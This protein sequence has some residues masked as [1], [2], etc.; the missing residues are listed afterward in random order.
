MT[1][2]KKRKLGAVTPLFEYSE[3]K[4]HGVPSYYGELLLPGRWLGLLLSA[5]GEQWH[6]KAYCGTK[7][8]SLGTVRAKF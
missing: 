3:S 1:A 5:R 6:S 4:M 7:A 8:G 2:A